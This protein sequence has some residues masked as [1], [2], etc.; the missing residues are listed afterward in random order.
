MTVRPKQTSRNT[1]AALLASTMVAALVAPVALAQ[2][3]TPEDETSV[4]DTIY[5]IA[6]DFVPKEGHSANKSD[7]ALIETPQ[8]VSVITRDQIDL[9]NFIDAQ[10]AVRYT[11]GVFGENYGPDLRFDFLKVRGFTP[12]EY[13]DGLATPNTTAIKSVGVDLYAFES[14]DVLKGP[15]S[16]LYGSAPPGG[17]Y[18]LNLRRP[19]DEFSGEISAKYGTDDYK[20]LAGTM[21]GPLGDAVSFSLTALY[22]DREAERDYVSAERHLLA[23]ALTWHMTP[24]T[25]LTLLGYYQSDIVMGDTNGFL[26]VYGTLL[27]NPVGKVSPSINLGSSDNRYDRDQWSIGYEFTHAF[28]EN[29]SFISNTKI[30]DYDEETPTGIYGS[31]GVVD[32]DFDG[33]PDDYRTVLQSNYTYRE[34]VESLATDNRFDIDLDAGGLQHDIIVG[35][36]YRDVDN[37]ADYGFFYG[38]DTIDLFD[39]VYDY[40]ADLT[41]GFPTAYVNQSLKQSGFYAQDHIGLGNLF[42]TLS[43]RYDDVKI[44]NDLTGENQKQDAFTYRVGANYVFDS[45]FAPYISYATSFEPVL[46]TDADTGEGFD[47]SEGEQVEAGI[48]YDA[49]G[50][51]DGYELLLTGAVYQINQKNIVTAAGSLTPVAAKQTGEV[52]VQGAEVELV[53]RIND[54]L[55][56]NASYSYTDSEVVDS[57]TPQEIGAELPVTPKHKAAVFVDYSFIDGPLAGFG[58]GGGVRYTGESQ[59]ALPGPF[60]PV[61]YTGEESTLVDAIIRYDTEDWRFALNGSNILD[62]EYVARCDGAA[63][64]TYGAGRQVIATVTRKF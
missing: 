53:S 59:G 38:T 20:Q 44:D 30:S 2:D 48:K 21:T 40:P 58:I 41:P 7:I 43:G 54:Q 19:Q 8:S 64:C 51:P 28:N 63:G 26:P 37:V 46:G 24:D 57:T 32:N 6:P 61:V 49:R 56:V 60:A 3:V 13:M 17:L 1:R 47:P 45:G 52:E 23:P 5:V 27:P 62:E 42:F 29:V 35:Y 16:A 34:K 4:Q 10:Q 36:D 9:L 18:N 12:K 11:S 25:D 55:S 31:G 15:G 14:F 39:P 33:V 22:R 50:L